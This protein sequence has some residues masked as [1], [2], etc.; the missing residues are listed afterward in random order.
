MIASFGLVSLW[1]RSLLVASLLDRLGRRRTHT[2]WQSGTNVA[3]RR[4]L[5]MFDGNGLVAYM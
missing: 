2:T 5:D 3:T 1:Q 4:D